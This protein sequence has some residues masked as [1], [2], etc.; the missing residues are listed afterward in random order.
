MLTRLSKREWTRPLVS[1]RAPPRIYIL[2]SDKRLSARCSRPL[3]LNKRTQVTSALTLI[4]PAQV[5]MISSSTNMKTRSL[6]STGCHLRHDFSAST[7]ADPSLTLTMTRTWPISMDKP[8]ILVTLR[9]AGHP[10]M[11]RKMTRKC[12]ISWTRAYIQ[13][14]WQCARPT[15]SAR[16]HCAPMESSWSIM[17]RTFTLGSATRCLARSL[18]TALRNAGKLCEVSTAKES[19]AATKSVSHLCGKDMSPTSLRRFS[20]AGMHLARPI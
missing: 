16:S 20:R 19:N 9:G 6:A 15:T 10:L 4:F 1:I 3:Q 5:T 7:M 2:L 18:S 8:R 17:S 12:S 11:S 14:T 13:S